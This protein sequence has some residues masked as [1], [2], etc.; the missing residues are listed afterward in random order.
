MVRDT[1]D[2]QIV[3]IY[4]DIDM[5]QPAGG[6][7]YFFGFQ[8]KPAKS[9]NHTTKSRKEIKTIICILKRQRMNH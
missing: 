4:S 3:A 8:Q 9:S 5:L 6:H 2:F 1:A 7:L